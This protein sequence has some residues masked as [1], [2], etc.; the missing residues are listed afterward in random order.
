MQLDNCSAYGV[1]SHVLVKDTLTYVPIGC[2]HAALCETFDVLASHMLLSSQSVWRPMQF[3]LPPRDT[4]S[5]DKQ[6]R[7][8]KPESAG[9]Q[10]FDLPAQQLTDET[11]RD[12]KLLQ[13]RGTFDPKRFYKSSDHK[14]GLPKFFQ[15]G[16][17]VEASADFY[18]G[19][20]EETWP[21]LL[22]MNDPVV[23]CLT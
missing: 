20:A 17:V 11:R 8:L 2:L 21:L 14:K 12:L 23:R 4:K 6:A 15:I 1:D 22:Q 5:I 18:S 13:L 3:N 19:V 9:K 10:W 7:K 16:T